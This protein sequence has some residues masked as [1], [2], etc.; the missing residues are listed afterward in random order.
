MTA[1]RIGDHDLHSDHHKNW[2]VLIL[3]WVCFLF[4][5]LLGAGGIWLITLGG[6]WYYALAGVGLIVTSVLLRAHRLSALWMYFLIWLATVIWAFW[7]VGTEWWAHVPR[8]VAPT[9]VLVAILLC[10]PAL[11]R[12]S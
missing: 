10:T 4:G 3:A 8:L 2:A 9:V 12:R 1:T 6:S 5:A 11:K 7:E